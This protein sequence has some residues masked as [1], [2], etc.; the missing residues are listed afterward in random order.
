MEAIRTETETKKVNNVEVIITKIEIKKEKIV[1]A[2]II[3]GDTDIKTEKK[4]TVNT[5][6]VIE[7]KD[8]TK[9]KATETTTKNK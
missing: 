9:M 2:I 7:E 1:E 5:K 4:V 8:T 6:R 3:K